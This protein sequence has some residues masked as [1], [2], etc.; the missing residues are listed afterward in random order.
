MIDGEFR[1]F[2]WA[3]AKKMMAKVGQFLESLKAF[4]AEEMSDKL[5]EKLTPI[6]NDPGIAYEV[7]MKKSDAA[8]NLAAWVINIFGY[9]RIYVKVK[10]LMD[11]LEAARNN[12]QQALD[13]LA[14]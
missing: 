1:N 4:K 2:K 7:M 12:K 5:I 8:A 9:N 10:P 11:S 6:V 13:K 14:A 3:R